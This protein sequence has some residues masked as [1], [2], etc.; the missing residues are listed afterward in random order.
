MKKLF[1]ILLMAFAVVLPSRIQA[2]MLDPVKWAFSIQEVDEKEFDLVATATVDP[3]YHI[4][5]TKM[6]DLGPKPTEFEFDLSKL[7]I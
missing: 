4:Y 6:P 2:Q 7:I 1:L 5:S 3:A